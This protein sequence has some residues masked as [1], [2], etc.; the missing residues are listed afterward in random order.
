MLMNRSE[1]ESISVTFAK[2]KQRLNNSTIWN[3]CFDMTEICFYAANTLCSSFS[4]QMMK[5]AACQMNNLLRR[6][7]Q[8]IKTKNALK[9]CEISSFTQHVRM[10]ISIHI[11]V[12]H[13]K[14]H[15]RTNIVKHPFPGVRY[16][17]SICFLKYFL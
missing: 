4:I 8:V 12:L 14:F 7:H 2:F 17:F 11:W 16:L 6:E 9:L 15:I 3:C 5:K 1:S 10:V 13:S